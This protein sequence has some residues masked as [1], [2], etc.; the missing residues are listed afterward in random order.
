M[1]ALRPLPLLVAITLLLPSCTGSGNSGDTRLDIGNTAAEPTLLDMPAGL[2]ELAPP[3]GVEPALWD[4]L[5]LALAASMETSPP[6]RGS[7][8]PV[9]DFAKS[10]FIW[11][12]GNGD[13]FVWHYLPGDYDQNG[14]VSISD[15][16]PLAVHFGKQVPAGN[17]N[18][19]EAV[20]DGDGNGSI[21][22]A[23]VTPIGVNFGLA[24]SGYRFFSSNSQFAIPI[25]ND[26][27]SEVQPYLAVD[28]SEAI[29]DRAKERLRYNGL[30]GT[31][32]SLVFYYW[33]R[34]YD[35]ADDSEGTPSEVLGPGNLPP[36]VSWTLDPLN[37]PLPFEM[38]IDASSSSDPNGD[39]LSFEWDPEDDGT[40]SPGSDSLQVTLEDSNPRTVGLRVSDG[41]GTR[42][43]VQITHSADGVP[44]WHQTVAI[45]RAGLDGFL[46]SV[47]AGV[48]DGRPWLIAVSWSN[49]I[50]NGIIDF[51]QSDEQLGEHWPSYRN[52]LVSTSQYTR[53]IDS[54]MIDDQPAFCLTSNLGSVLFR[55]AVDLQ[56]WDWGDL[57]YVAGND[58]VECSM[59]VSGGRPM[60][61]YRNWVDSDLEII[62]ADNPEG[63]SWSPPLKPLG[64][65]Q[66]S[67]HGASLSIVNGN[68]AVA[69]YDLTDG[70]LRYMDSFRLVP[71]GAII[72]NNPV[73]VEPGSSSR[74]SDS[75]LVL[76]DGSP[77]MAFLK[78]DTGQL[79]FRRAPGPEGDSFVTNKV[80]ASGLSVDVLNVPRANVVGG[81]VHVYYYDPDSDALMHVAA[82]NASG[83]SWQSPDLVDSQASGH[84]IPCPFEVLG[85]PAVAYGDNG[86][87]QFRYAIF[88]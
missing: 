34:P 2:G 26:A 58:A 75:L 84:V 61:A 37:G 35:A 72:W 22:I 16:T 81:I 21:T 59:A 73:N 76:Q 79:V 4:E 55:R 62:R 9:S 74:I 83:S 6:R 31:P 47:T 28:I 64:M 87:R 25:A 8:A 40:F 20:V 52:M 57:Q 15:L 36:D 19:I 5:R 38:T 86:S 48:Q 44:N 71:S 33:A 54:V 49:T 67:G 18:S 56:S 82:T 51:N 1:L 29:G 78:V 30:L 10:P 46:S 23:D 14:V 13:A 63:S 70:L 60:I 7:S 88:Y 65:A 27:P 69:Y 77:A 11:D 43:T 17:P 24:V 85:Q 80:L 41:T 45:D 32:G 12:A 3:E 39:P 53:Y 68:A 50:S 42:R 66:N